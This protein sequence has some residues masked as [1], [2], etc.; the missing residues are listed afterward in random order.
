METYKSCKGI[1]ASYYLSLSLCIYIRAH[2]HTHTIVKCDVMT[3][4]VIAARVLL[5]AGKSANSSKP[6]GILLSTLQKAKTWLGKV[7]V[8]IAFQPWKYKLVCK[9]QKRNNTVPLDIWLSVTEFN[10][11]QIIS[12]SFEHRCLSVSGIMSRYLK[13]GVYL[14][15]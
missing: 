6:R 15:S 7:L 1:C 3:S 2:M 13:N 11:K 10:G 5:G 12:V 9:K 4:A 14:Y 8:E